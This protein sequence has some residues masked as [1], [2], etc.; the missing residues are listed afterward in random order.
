ML[1]LRF[2]RLSR[3]LIIVLK[4]QAIIGTYKRREIKP[5]FS[6][7]IRLYIRILIFREINSSISKVLIVIAKFFGLR[8]LADDKAEEF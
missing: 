7:S 1:S 4:D 6:I 8:R 3:H 2:K 5:D